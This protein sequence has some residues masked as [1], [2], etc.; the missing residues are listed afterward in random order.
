[1]IDTSILSIANPIQRDMVKELD[2]EVV[3]GNNNN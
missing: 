1:L 3:R 2:K